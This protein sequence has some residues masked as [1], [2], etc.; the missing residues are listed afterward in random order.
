[1]PSITPTA[2]FVLPTLLR[3]GTKVQQ[4]VTLPRPSGR[5]SSKFVSS[6]WNT[7]D[8]LSIIYFARKSLDG[9]LTWMPHGGFTAIS[10]TF[11][12]DGVTK[13]EPG[14]VWDWDGQASL[15]EVTVKVTIPFVFGVTTSFMD[16]ATT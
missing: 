11:L 7:I 3:A 5:V 13:V 1:M 14:G 8:G 15:F 4:Y 9:G 10:P 2:D 6:D 16:P 12:R